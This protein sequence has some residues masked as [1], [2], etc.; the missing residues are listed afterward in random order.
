MKKTNKKENIQIRALD[1]E[2]I[3]SLYQLLQQLTPL[4]KSYFHPHPFDHETLRG[5]SIDRK[6]HYFVMLL[7]YKIIGYSFL[8][9]FGYEI[10]SFGCCIHTRYQNRGYGTF[11]TKWTLN[12]ARELGYKK[13]TLKTYKENIPAQKIYKKTGFIIAGKTQDKKQYKM[14]IKL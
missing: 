14:E 13:V 6:G 11:L 2:D 12:K 3:N 7:N 4:A 9:L 1:L 5:I 8:R 10:P